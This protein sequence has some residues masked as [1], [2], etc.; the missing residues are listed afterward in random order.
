CPACGTPVERP[1]DE[2]MIYCPNTACPARIYWSLVHFVSQ[3][4]MD[5]RGLGERTIAQLLD[6]EMVV[7]VA[8]LYKLT[9]ADLLELEGFADISAQ[10][11]INSIEASKEQPLSRVLIALGIRHV[12]AHAAQ[13]LARH[14]RTMRAMLNAS[15]DEFAAIHGIGR[16]TAEAL[17]TFLSEQRNRQV[18]DRLAAAGV[19]MQ[20]E[21][22]QLDDAR[23]AGLSFVITGTL[24]T[25]SRKE[26]T[27]FVESRGGRISSSVSKSTDFVVVG[28]DP[29][30]K[31][32]KAKQLGVRVLDEDG[33]RKLSDEL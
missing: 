3:G 18:I 19:N 30:S 9:R 10:N 6:R 28:D 27:E 14:Y 33:L 11:L 21:V 32:E 5:I 16:T 2:V 15:A 7:D 29:G 31:F 23:F 8:D 17:A 12:G 22:Q 24:P 13:V 20:E 4:A 26:A 1:A 25:M